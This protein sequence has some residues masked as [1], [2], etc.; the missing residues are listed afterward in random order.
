M[1]YANFIGRVGALAL[2]LG[3]GAATVTMPAI[4]FAETDSD[5]SSNSDNE[6][7]GS[8]SGQ[9]DPQ[10]GI[11]SQQPGNN[12]LNDRSAF[13]DKPNSLTD[14]ET[15]NPSFSP[16]GAIDIPSSQKK[17]DDDLPA[18]TDEEDDELA[19][20]DEDLGLE[21]PDVTPDAE[22]APEPEPVPEPE[23]EPEPRSEPKPVPVP[24]PVPNGGNPVTRPSNNE[25]LNGAA[26]VTFSRQKPRAFEELAL[27]TTVDTLSLIHI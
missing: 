14:K 9:N 20:E 12:S 23:P 7:G 3:F 6:K 24:V 19:F 18:L 27:D 4:A 17:D 2:A 1:G 10:D 11:D 8:P 15:D 16:T 13:G 26:A 5:T 21:G 22:V 25:A